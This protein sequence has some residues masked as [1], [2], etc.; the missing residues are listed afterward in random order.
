MSARASHARH[1]QRE[2]RAAEDRATIE[3]TQPRADGSG[4]LLERR[5][6][7]PSRPSFCQL[8]RRE[9]ENQ[10][11]RLGAGRMGRPVLGSRLC[12]R[13]VPFVL[14]RFHAVRSRSGAFSTRSSCA[15]TAATSSARDRIRLAELRIGT[16]TSR[17][18]WLSYPFGPIRG[19]ASHTD[20]VRAPRTIERPDA[21]GR[22]ASPSERQHGH[23]PCGRGHHTSRHSR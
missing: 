2:R 19:C 14:D 12:L 23:P 8:S 9:T 1:Q 13:R 20:R 21:T 22:G 17:A 3:I 6:V 11:R 18:T 16:V 15:R 10:D 4:E 5:I 7:D